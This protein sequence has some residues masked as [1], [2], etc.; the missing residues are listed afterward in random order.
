L[1]WTL[2]SIYT[3]GAYCNTPLRECWCEHH[4]VWVNDLIL[5]GL[6]QIASNRTIIGVSKG[7]SHQQGV[8]CRYLR[9]DNDQILPAVE[10]SSYNPLF[11]LLIY[12]FA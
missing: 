4:F 8:L 6:I 2:I 11:C 9:D 5:S 10:D 3:V 7:R 12:Y 1:Q